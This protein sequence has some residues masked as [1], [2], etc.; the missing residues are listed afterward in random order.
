[1]AVLRRTF[2]GMALVA[3][4]VVA[5]A[6]PFLVALPRPAAALAPHAPIVIL[7]NAG[8]NATNGVVG[9]AGTADDPYVI[10]GWTI[11]A[12][13]AMGVQIRGTSAH[14]VVR[15]VVV[16][17]A[18][19][20]G[21]YAYDVS[22]LTFANVTAA[23]SPGDG[24]LL[25]SSHDVL[26]DASN[27]TA[28]LAGVEIL[29]SSNVSL[30]AN[31]VTLNAGDGVAVASSTAVLVQGNTFWYDAVGRG[32]ALDVV[33]STNATILGNRFTGSGIYLD[34]S[35][36]ED[37]ASHTITA[38]NLVSGFP[39]LYVAGETGFTYSGLTLGELLL[40]DCTGANV[41]DMSI[42][43]GAV[44]V[45]VAFSRSIVLGPNLTLAAASTG[46]HVVSSDRVRFF[47]GS[48]LE[49]GTGAS[50][51]S[52]SDVSLAGTKVATPFP[53]GLPLSGIAVTDSQR[54]N[55]SQDIVRHYPTGI[56]VS[57]SGNLSLVGNVVA[58]NTVGLSLSASSDLLAVGNLVSQDETGLAADQ[59]TN[60]TFSANVF[61]GSLVG[62][63]V[64]ASSGL[65]FVGNAFLGDQTNAFDGNGTADA[66]DGG[67][68]VGGNY[69]WTY[70][71]RDAYSG[72]GQNLTGP[73]GIGDVP[74]AFSVDAVDRF[75]LMEDP[76]AADA[77][78]EALFLISPP[79]GT[80]VSTFRVTANVSS[81]YED[82]LAQLQVRWDWEGNG[83]W[84]PW[85]NVKYAQHAY[86]VPGVHEMRLEVRDLAGLTDT[87]TQAVYVAPKPDYLPPAIVTVP[88]ASA[89]VGQPIPIVAN[90]TDPS[91]VFNATLLY[92][93]VDG[94]PFESIAR[95][96]NGRGANFTATI[97]AQPHAGTVD[98]VI[99]ANDTWRNEA[100][101]PL[102][103]YAVVPV[104]DPTMRL[105]LTFGVPA[106]IIAAAAAGYLWYRRRR[107][108]V[109]RQ[110]EETPPK[111]GGAP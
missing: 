80:V 44:G 35:A 1:M 46:L 15:D 54:V 3:A 29:A 12:P 51:Q 71:G 87:W 93:G 49:A 28:N 39:V 24:I 109:P 94:G 37:Y 105:L 69:W 60:G 89:D 42:A 85:T 91:G 111:N 79:V 84:T 59:L 70:G 78:P 17:S 62:A 92:R 110:G 81:D 23:T 25:E 101:A 68:P 66:W 65:R 61:Q 77:P 104:V 30:V 95:V 11:S 86:R 100:R 57:S 20:A 41:S 13:P 72:P 4:L 21:F 22:N 67:Y 52:S 64:S 75:P 32:Y 88:L 2:A 102:S 103:G 48:I 76:V 40:A 96:P 73:D 31:N 98:Y 5:A 14:A 108:Q 90:I 74:Y 18:P 10:A 106:A 33:S 47:D 43:G 53:V 26:V 63:N 36:P 55:L 19:L 6:A 7:G 9:G 83:T 99:V 107:R 56:S 8:F 34:G 45:E 27:L 97:P 50:I 58:L 16:T 38:D 82:S